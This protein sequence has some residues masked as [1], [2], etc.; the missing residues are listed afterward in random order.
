MVKSNFIFL[1]FLICFFMISKIQLTQIKKL[2][3]AKKASKLEMIAKN[4]NHVKFKSVEH[5]GNSENKSG[6]NSGTCP[7]V[8]DNSPQ[9]YSS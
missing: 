5:K 6:M 3:S 1:L 9:I 4:E 2:Y 7:N 8:N